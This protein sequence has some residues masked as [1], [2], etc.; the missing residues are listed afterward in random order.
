MD[1]IVAAGRSS[2][3]SPGAAWRRWAGWAAPVVAALWLRTDRLASQVL[4]GDELHALS[5][6]ALLDLPTILRTFLPADACIPL[7]ALFRVLM[8]AGVVLDE[9]ILRLPA[10]VA[11]VLVPLVLPWMLEPRVGERAARF[12]A[13][14]LALSPGLVLY[15]RIVR[16]YAIVSLLG[17][18]A[19]IAFLRWW[20]GGSRRW[21]CVY[22]V[23]APLTVWF[24]LAA[25][26]FVAG[27]PALAWL[28]RRSDARRPAWRALLAIS[29]A[30]TVLVALLLLPTFGSGMP[31]LSAGNF[32]RHNAVTVRPAQLVAALQ[33]LLGTRAPAAGGCV[34][35]VALIGWIA[36]ARRD[37][38]LAVGSA[39]LFGGL[40]AGFLWLSPVGLANPVVFHRYLLVATLCPL[41]WVAVALDAAARWFAARRR[42]SW[43]VATVGL[44]LAIYAAAGP[45]LDPARR[46]SSY[47]HQESRLGYVLPAVALAA[48]RE[49]PAFYRWLQATGRPQP[50]VEY[51]GT[52]TWIDLP[53]LPVY[54]AHHRQP[55]QF[56]PAEQS[57]LFS[58]SLALRSLVAPGAEALLASGA[59]WLVV[60]ARVEEENRWLRRGRR[61]AAH[62]FRG[63]WI[64][65]A[66][67][68]AAALRRELTEAWGPAE[69]CDGVVEAWSLA[70]QRG[71]SVVEVPEGLRG[72]CAALE[73]ASRP[74][75]DQPLFASGFESGT[76]S[77]WSAA[78]PAPRAP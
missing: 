67:V 12:L 3:R 46:W 61:S 57:E 77:D 41:L 21:A 54:Q 36:L 23:A 30:A 66:E 32:D 48:E 13:W 38:D 68:N 29:S 75:V 58:P 51:L 37:R 44:S 63:D 65:R 27:P 55:V 60:H 39:F 52:P 18:V 33:L 64:G 47:R 28:T 71:E 50:L 40:V 9:S 5:A 19:A 22:L 73:S 1:E 34:A 45:L 2:A 72:P 31:W 17:G 4:V 69:A 74:Q 16:P 8:D 25:L 20:S 35:L 53:L 42:E 78:E 56:A 76:A 14:L 11:G 49:L 26:P 43:G 62:P 7:T 70:R 6:A 24:H 59:T 10:L 15:S